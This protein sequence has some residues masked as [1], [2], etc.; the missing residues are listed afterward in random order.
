MAS[1]T[2]GSL[3]WLGSGS[4]TRM[5]CTWFRVRDRV[6]DRVRVYGWAA[7]AAAA[8]GCQHLAKAEVRVRV[9]HALGVGC[10]AFGLG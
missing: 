6:R 10:C 3:I 8:Q 7:A 5:P 1:S 2:S 4:Y 9:G